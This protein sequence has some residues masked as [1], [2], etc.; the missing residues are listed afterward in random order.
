MQEKIQA[1]LATDTL[2]DQLS[3]HASPV[4]AVAVRMCTE[5]VKASAGNSSADAVQVLRKGERR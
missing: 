5:N 2:H 4:S 1:P 3:G